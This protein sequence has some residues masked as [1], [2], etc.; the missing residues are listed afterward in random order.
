MFE[1]LFFEAPGK[2]G[3]GVLTGF[4]EQ[5]EP[6]CGLGPLEQV[7]EAQP[8]SLAPPGGWGQ[9]PPLFSPFSTWLGLTSPIWVQ[10]IMICL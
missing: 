8:R 4:Q 6:C 1:V 7:R 3:P 2:E 9:L 10:K 5:K